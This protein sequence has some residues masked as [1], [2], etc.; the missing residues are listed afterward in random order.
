[1]QCTK[2]VVY[3]QEK[4]QSILRSSAYPGTYSYA[5]SYFMMIVQS[6]AKV[7]TQGKYQEKLQISV[8]L[9][10]HVWVIPE[11][12]QMCQLGVWL[13]CMSKWLSEIVLQ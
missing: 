9:N 7:S 12:E 6:V 1:M 5:D 10:H 3:D 11:T 8:W 13:R 4:Y 2:T